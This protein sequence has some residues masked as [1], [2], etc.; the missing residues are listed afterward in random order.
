MHKRAPPTETSTTSETGEPRL[1][2]SQRLS[3]CSHMRS[4]FRKYSFAYSDNDH[5]DF[6]YPYNNFYF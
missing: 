2:A 5:E 1:G 3:A 4:N 6:N